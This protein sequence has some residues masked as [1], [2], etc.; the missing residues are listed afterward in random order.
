MDHSELCCGFIPLSQVDSLHSPDYRVRE[1]TTSDLILTLQT[2]PPDLV[3][4]EEFLELVEPLLRDPNMKVVQNSY[5]MIKNLITALDQNCALYVHTLVRISLSLYT[6]TRKFVRKFCNELI[7]QLLKILSPSSVLTE[8]VRTLNNS[9]PQVAVECLDF[10]DGLVQFNIIPSVLLTQFTFYLDNALVSPHASVQQAA[11]KFLSSLQFRDPSTYD[12][13][14]GSFKP[15]SVQAVERSKKELSGQSRRSAVISRN[16]ALSNGG[17][18]SLT[19]L[20]ARASTTQQKST[21]NINVDDVVEKPAEGFNFQQLPSPEEGISPFNDFE[22]GFTQG[23]AGRTSNHHFSLFSDEKAASPNSSNETFAIHSDFSN[24]KPDL[25]GNDNDDDEEFFF[26]SLETPKEK[27]E[28]ENKLPEK[29]EEKSPE[30]NRGDMLSK[31]APVRVTITNSPRLDD[32]IGGNI[33]DKRAITVL[34]RKNKDKKSKIIK[35]R[36]ALSRMLKARNSIS[37]GAEPHSIPNILDDFQP[38]ENATEELTVKQ[39]TIGD[40]SIPSRSN[41]GREKKRMASSMKID[42]KAVPKVKTMQYQSPA[43][44]FKTLFEKLHSSEWSDQN[45]AILALQTNINELHQ[46]MDSNSREMVQIL[47]EC[48]CSLRT[49]LAKNA[50]SLL[51]VMIRDPRIDCTTAGET[52][53]ASLLHIVSAGR[54]FISAIACDC[55]DA[56]VECMNPARAS[57]MLISES[58]RKQDKA[59]SRVA[60]GIGI[61]APLC[62]NDMMLRKVCSTLENDA[63]QDVRRMARMSAAKFP[64]A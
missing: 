36:M 53:G 9:P 7:T 12:N 32:I 31:T 60:A 19:R 24:T 54:Q 62:P 57:A 28:D 3:D 59:R 51:L 5:I 18:L 45:D 40:N 11:N 61:I 21:M 30:F 44:K 50:L 17:R 22:T 42:T 29:E 47:A 15:E 46:Q 16:D 20:F 2:T 25:R 49:A 58:K 38:K 37:A 6:D 26:E 10:V 1:Q 14:I 33:Q 41:F 23:Y 56:L 52:A 64:S 63:N 35:E 8:I 48:G 43:T 34:P 55:F 39:V 4:V 13:I 27:D